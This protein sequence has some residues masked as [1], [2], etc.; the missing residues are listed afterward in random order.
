MSSNFDFLKDDFP[1]M[2]RRVYRAE[3]RVRTEPVSSVQYSRLVL[4][5]VLHFI[6][7]EEVLEWPY[8]V[9]IYTLLRE[10]ELWTIVPSHFKREL[11]I[12]RRHG[13]NGAHYGKRVR[14]EEAL[15]CIKYLFNFLKWFSN[16]YA[17][18]Q[19]ELPGLFDESH[20]PKIGAEKRQLKAIQ[21]EAAKAQQALQV[22]LDAALA[23][24]EKAMA[25]A[26]ASEEKLEAYRKAQ[27]AKKAKLAEQKAARPYK[28][29][30]AF[31]ESETRQHLIDLALQEA[32]WHELNEGREKEYPV[33]GMP[34][35]KNN[36]KGNGFA[37]Y[38]LWGD[39][40][41]PLAVIEAKRTGKDA[42]NG[43][44][45]AK[46]YADCLE[47]MHG[48]RPVIF[49]TNGY[50]T[51]IWDDTFY[52]TS[53]RVYGF[54]NKEELE[55][56]I[57]KRQ[58]RKD[59]R[60]AAINADI[61]GRP[62]QMEGIRRLAESWV[63][64][65]ANGQL[66]GAKRE[67]LLVMATG[68][69]KTRTSASVVDILTK[70][71]WAKRVLFLA[72]RNALVTQAK[73]AYNEYLPSLSAI[74][75]TQEKENNTTRLVFSTYQSIINKIDSTKD[76]DG[77]F[78][79][80]GH[81]DLIIVDEAHRSVYNKFG[82]IFEYFDAL[83]LGL[84]ATP[85]NAVDK[86]TFELFGCT[87]GNPTFSYE[88]EEA[89]QSGFLVPY[90]NIKVA[91]QFVREGIKYAELSEAEKAQYEEQFRDNATGLF[92]EEIGN[93]AINR[94]LFNKDTVYKVL[95]T[96]MQEGLKIEGGDKIGRTIIFAVNQKHAKFIVDCFEERY[97]DLSSSF[98]AQ[99]SNNVSHVQ[100]IIQSF[101]NKIE[102]KPPQIAVSVDMMD[103]GVDAPRVVNLVFFKVVRSYAKFWQMIGRG[104]R[105]CPDV[106][107]E[108]LP[109]EYFL[110]FDVCE[111]FEFFDEKS[112]KKEGP[113]AKPVT[114][115]I[116]L[117]RLAVARLLL[118][119]GEADDRVLAGEYLNHLH[120]VVKGL[121]KERFDVQM[122]RAYVDQFEQREAWNHLSPEHI[123]LIEDHLSPLPRPEVINERARRF[124][125]MCLK[126]LQANLLMRSSEQRYHNNLTSIADGLSKKYSIEAV[127]KAKST[128]EALRDPD[129]YKDLSHRKMEEIRIEIRELVQYLDKAD[130]SPIYTNFAD[131]VSIEDPGNTYFP[132]NSSE[133]YK[134]RVRRFIEENKHHITISKLNTNQPIT[135]AELEALQ[136]ILFDG[137]E[138]GTMDQYR[139]VFDDQPLGKF[140][141]SIVGLD[142]RAAQALFADFIQQGNLSADQIRFI[143]DIIQHLS[144][145]GTIDKSL[146]VKSPFTDYA[147]DGLFGVFQRED[148]LMKIIQL[149]DRVNQNAEAG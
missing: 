116:F 138:R 7:K 94:W 122:Q 65:G 131:E 83:L 60:T 128:I 93:S 99:I 72:D 56:A 21:A 12:I 110:I 41:L 43:R 84:T 88:L 107:G 53:R 112:N 111:N 117:S 120:T 102:E 15:I 89:V 75:L 74:D 80:V 31:N 57:Q 54:Y 78:Y 100:T 4:E 66:R 130:R 135:E 98:I 62:Y 70:N 136:N 147:S 38:V 118:E 139:E 13:N 126:M 127:L 79:G 77:R 8:E 92:P 86:N 33:K 104:T 149:I 40:G 44:Y 52:S 81:F 125:L 2:Y 76:D 141:R 37:D 95:D 61:S 55:W 50:E 132:Q 146:L 148:Q 137:E 14:S 134:K 103:T 121:D 101:C 90:Q 67:A 24:A 71:N 58:T 39:N 129:F 133:L 119:T 106:F 27:E 5:E 45:Q 30:S 1:A 96:L 35:G 9:N 46:L 36:P 29:S 28:A 34:I 105:L 82:V 142:I 25:A 17:E 51:Y 143:D 115:Q 47:E 11:D 73:N 22:Q 144:H 91:T 49:Y 3:Q 145:N 108:G 16:W 114:Q 20:I 140:I 32:G 97:P 68:S 85:K 63:T 113:T 26:Q 19:P 87:D 124:D 23:K 59:I 123:Q 6:Y 42:E 10:D 48:Q 64:S 109:K 69:G 18:E